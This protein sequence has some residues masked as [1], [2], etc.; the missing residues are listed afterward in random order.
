MTTNR[1]VVV[2]HHSDLTSDYY[3]PFVSERLA[4]EFVKDLPENEQ[5]MAE[6]KPLHSRQEYT[7]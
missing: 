6:I 2:N 4:D 5:F 1:F 7:P 3:G